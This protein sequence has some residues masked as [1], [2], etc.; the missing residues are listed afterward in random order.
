EP[1]AG[2]MPIPIDSAAYHD[3]SSSAAF[4]GPIEVCVTYDQNDVGSDESEIKL[5]HYELGAWVEIT[6]SRDIENNVI[7]GETSS[8]SSFIVARSSTCCLPPTVGDIDQSGG[9]DITDI[10]VL[11]DNQFLTLTPLVC[12]D[13]GDIDFS[14]ITDITDLSI[15][16]DNQF[17]S[18]TPL[19]PCP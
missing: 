18:L 5:F 12:E 14:G 2:F 10:S 7:C 8:L 13:E 17:L 4:A 15:L 9:V 1:P 19:P 16:I 11:I 6:S 3:I